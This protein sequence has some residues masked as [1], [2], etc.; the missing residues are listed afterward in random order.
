MSASLVQCTCSQCSEPLLVPG[1][2][3]TRLTGT[4]STFIWSC[5]LLTPGIRRMNLN[6]RKI[7]LWEYVNFKV[8]IKTT[9]IPTYHKCF[10]QRIWKVLFSYEWI[11]ERCTVYWQSSVNYPS[12]PNSTLQNKYFLGWWVDDRSRFLNTSYMILFLE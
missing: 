9:D 4:T 7:P 5:T 12:N 1:Q 8:R 11:D 10:K 3:E 6:I 2:E